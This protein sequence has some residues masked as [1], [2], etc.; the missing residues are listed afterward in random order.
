MA[1]PAILASRAL[2]LVVDAKVP[3]NSVVRLPSLSRKTEIT[4]AG[5][6]PA[7]RRASILG[8]GFISIS[9]S[10]IATANNSFKPTLPRLGS[11]CAYR[12]GSAA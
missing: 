7:A 2:S 4:I 6:S 12:A 5:A 9:P 3:M 8:S 1:F 10:R 11:V